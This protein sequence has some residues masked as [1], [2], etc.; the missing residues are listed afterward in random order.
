MESKKNQLQEYF[1]KRDFTQLPVYSHRQTERGWV[2]TL[3]LPAG[4]E[5]EGLGTNKKSAD[6]EAATLALSNFSKSEN[7]GVLFKFAGRV[8]VLI[9]LENT[10]V[11]NK[12]L[13]NIIRWDR[14]RIEAFVGKLSSHA[15]KDLKD[16]YPF[17]DRFHI[18]DSGHK[19]AVDH[20]ISVRAGEWLGAQKYHIDECT[21]EEL[22]LV[23]RDRFASALIDVLKQKCN[24]FTKKPKLVHSIN[25]DECFQFLNN[26]CV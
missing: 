10:P 25:I 1:Q 23:S 18:I 6:Q 7:Q 4:K 8:L 2:S 19:D 26:K 21:Y 3:K 16:L 24:R 12:N 13:W 5:F 20:A 9:D 22:H 14:S 11:H 15:R 17:V